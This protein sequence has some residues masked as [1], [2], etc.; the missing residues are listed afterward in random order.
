MSR[1]NRLLLLV[2]ALTGGL[3]LALEQPWRGDA[4]QRTAAAVRP[5][6]PRLRDELQ[7]VDRVWIHD[8]DHEVTLVRGT[9]GFVV[10]EALGHP[11]DRVRLQDFLRRLA[12]LQSRDVVSTNPEKRSIYGVDEGQGT[13][14]EIRDHDG[15][16]LADL[17]G[18]RLRSQDPRSGRKV[19]L[20]F[21]VRPRDR[22]EVI[23]VSDYAAP[24]TDPA[25]WIAGRFWKLDSESIQEMQRLSPEP[26]ESWRIHRIPA[27]DDPATEEREDH[28]WVMDQPEPGRNVPL[29]AGD[30]WCFS[31]SGLRAAGVV[32]QLSPGERPAPNFGLD[33]AEELRARSANREYRLFLGT[34][35]G[36]A[37]R[38]A[39]SPGSP[40]VYTIPEF[41][42]GQLRQPSAKM[43][44]EDD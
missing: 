34:V 41:D 16:V 3:A 13:A 17:I 23:L 38:Y 10:E 19:S 15:A 22:D 42:A 44:A 18:G 12:D 43:L 11:A 9:T 39:W 2:L 31:F 37:R 14:I 28:A 29:Y 20:D 40:W 35:A 36:P 32:A 5:L 33:G 26:G 30:S 21:Y 6:F 25:D 24:S 1:Q 7:R 4:V 27:E 8:A